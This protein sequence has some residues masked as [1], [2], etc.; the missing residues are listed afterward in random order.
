MIMNDSH[1]TDDDDNDD[2]VSGGW[3]LLEVVATVPVG[4]RFSAVTDCQSLQS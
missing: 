4:R 3:S 1:Y 2:D